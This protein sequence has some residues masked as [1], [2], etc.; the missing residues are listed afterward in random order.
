MEIMEIHCDIP[1][2]A[3]KALASAIVIEIKSQGQRSGIVVLTTS[4]RT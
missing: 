4:V 1:G 3:S 2:S